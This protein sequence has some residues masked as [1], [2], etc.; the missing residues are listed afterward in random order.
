[1]QQIRLEQDSQIEFLHVNATLMTLNTLFNAFLPAVGRPDWIL[2][3]RNLRMLA[4]VC[5]FCRWSA[6]FWRLFFVYY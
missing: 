3:I 5:S 4:F 1:M 6:N 2:I